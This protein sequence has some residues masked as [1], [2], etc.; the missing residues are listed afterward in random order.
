V[1]D[2][3]LYYFGEKRFTGDLHRGGSWKGGI[4]HYD[5][6][7]FGAYDFIFLFIGNGYETDVEGLAWADEVLK[8]YPDRTAVVSTHYYLNANGTKSAG[9]KAIYDNLV[10]PNENVQLVLCGHIHGTATVKQR[11]R[12]ADGSIRQVTE[13]LADYQSNPFGGEGFLRL[14]TFDPAN[15]RLSVKTYSPW[16]DKWNSFGQAKDEFELEFEF[17][18]P[19][20]EL[21]TDYFSAEVFGA[22]ILATPTLA[23]T[24]GPQP[25]GSVV[26]VAVPAVGWY[27]LVKDGFGGASKSAIMPASTAP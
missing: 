18:Q 27:A 10:V 2:A 9:G 22:T 6:L 12:R 26:N 14:L 1:Y 16:L 4:H 13:M 23:P 3:Y 8:A 7:S 20:K 25:S 11:I 19:V 17:L 24:L 5:L 21:T 15:A